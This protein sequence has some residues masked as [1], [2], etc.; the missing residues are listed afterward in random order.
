[1]HCLM[2]AQESELWRCLDQIWRH[3]HISHQGLRWCHIDI[4]VT[5]ALISLQLVTIAGGSILHEVLVRLLL[6]TAC[7]WQTFL[8]QWHLNDATRVTY[9]PHMSAFLAVIRCRD[10]VVRDTIRLHV[11]LWPC[12]WLIWRLQKS[13][14]LSSIV[15]RAP[16]RSY[17][18]HIPL[19]RCKSLDE[20]LAHLTRDL[21]ALTLGFNMAQNAILRIPR[22]C[23]Q[24][25]SALCAHCSID[26]CWFGKRFFVI[27]A[28]SMS[29]CW[30][31]LIPWFQR[32]FSCDFADFSN[33]HTIKGLLA[34]DL[35]KFSSIAGLCVECTCLRVVLVEWIHTLCLGWGLIICCGCWRGLRFRLFLHLLRKLGNNGAFWAHNVVFWLNIRCR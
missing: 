1:M 26:T 2:M 20:I 4:C 28:R 14:A 9:D 16:D 24:F 32:R 33:F 27:F 7:D 34:C 19:I 15:L 22:S 3:C 30:W 6:G 18:R 13:R 11:S 17:S 10:D 21:V 35:G 12:N 25:L 29:M 8:S 31:K 23:H 5:T